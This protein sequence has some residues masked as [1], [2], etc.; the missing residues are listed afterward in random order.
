MKHK[1]LKPVHK[2]FFE[3]PTLQL[4]EKLLGSFLIHE[5][6]NGILAGKIVE[7]EAY[8]GPEDR[9]A[10]SFNHRRT[11]RTEIMFHEAGLAY[12]YTMHTHNLM[13]VVTGRM[14]QPHAILIRGMEPIIGEEVMLD[15]R[16]VTK[17]TNLT[18]GPGKLTK[19]MAIDLSH[20]GHQLWEKPLYIADGENPKEIK[21]GRR[22]G[23]PNA[24]EAVAYPYRFWIGNNPFVSR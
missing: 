17:R 10:H 9:A 5:T 7:T 18:S 1:Q 8:M 23:I 13:N 21:A 16:P 4:A 22:I 24:K 12:I 6:P 3:K 11:K 19:A 2:S 14:N 20:Y 15:N